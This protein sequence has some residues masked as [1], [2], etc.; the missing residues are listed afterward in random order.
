MHL[1][2]LLTAKTYEMHM[3][4]SASLKLGL[5][6]A[7]MSQSREQS[8]EGE[9]KPKK[10]SDKEAQAKQIDELLKKGAYDVFREEDDA[11]AEKFME[12]DIDQ[13][14]EHSSRVTYGA[15]A[16]SSLGSGL[17]SFS[18]ASFVA[19]TDDGTK[20]VDL[21]DPE[22]WSKAVGLD[23]QEETPEEIAQMLD[24]G[25]KRSRKQVQV[26]DPH[27]DTA[28]AEQ[29]KKDKIALEKLLEKEEKE[30]L[31]HEQ[32]VKKQE[33]K[34][35]KRRDKE[36][37]EKVS[38]EKQYDTSSKPALPIKLLPLGITK[39]VKDKEVFEP[40][41]KKSKKNERMQ[42][43]KKAENA[44][45][46]LERLKQAWEVPQR[47]RAIAAA[48]RF[49]FARFCK[50]RSESNLSGLPL[51]DLES[52]LRAFI[53]QLSLQVAVSLS[54]QSRTSVTSNLR[55]LLKEWL[56][57]NS[58]QELNW[59]CD[60]VRTALQSQ[61]EVENLERE[62]R[63]PLILTDPA[64]IA[65]LRQ[66]AALRSLR[67]IGILSRL[68]CF[69][70]D[71][72][73][74]ILGNLGHES[75]GK[76]GCSS[77][78]LATLDADLKARFVTTEELSL[79][80]GTFY[81][82]LNLKAPATWWDRDCDISLLVGSF[83]HG[84]GNYESMRNDF[85]LPFLERIARVSQYDAASIDAAEIFRTASSAAV[86]VFDDALEAA[87]VKAELEVQAAVAA[88]AKAASKREEDAALLRKG[89]AEAEAVMSEMP[90][91]QVED[92]FAF[93][94]TDSHFVTLP[95]LIKHVHDSVRDHSSLVVKEHENS[96]RGLFPVESKM[97][98]DLA[99]DEV[100]V[101]F[102][103]DNGEEERL[104]SMPDARVLDFRLRCILDAVEKEAHSDSFHPEDWDEP[105]SEPLWN[106][107]PVIM[108]LI[109]VHKHAINEFAPELIEIA[110]EFSGIGIG[111][112]QC[113]SS[114]RTLNDGSD[115]G[116]GPASVKLSQ[117]AYG[118]EAPRYLRALGV[119]MNLTRY[120]ITGLVHARESC[121][122]ELLA[123]ESLRYYG[124][125]DARSASRIT[126]GE[127]DLNGETKRIQ[128][129]C[130]Q[131]DTDIEKAK[132][133]EGVDPNNRIPC[134]FLSNADL[135]AMTCVAVLFFGFPLKSDEV[136]INP[137]LL[138][139]LSK[140][141]GVAVVN[142]ALNS[143][144][145]ESF[146]DQIV[147]ALPSCTVPDITQL[148][149]Y[150][151]KFLLPH[152]LRLCVNGNGSSTRNARGS[153]G[154]Y[155]TAFGVSVHPEPSKPQPSP[156]PDP[157]VILE[158]HSLESVGYANAILRRVQLLRS[159]IYVCSE[160]FEIVGNLTRSES[161]GYLRDMPIWWCP[162]VHDTAL[163][164]QVAS[165]GV[166][167]ILKNRIEHPIFKPKSVEDFFLAKLNDTS[168]T[169]LPVR[170]TDSQKATAWAKKHSNDFPSLFQLERRLAH[171]CSK[172]TVGAHDDYRYD[173]V[174]MFD[175]GAWPR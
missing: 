103:N 148:A 29:R 118:T 102:T 76:R 166:F 65:E 13:L 48:I 89:G 90:D 2:S 6:R 173:S 39:E 123:G 50:L 97:D 32:K 56:G 117:V 104:L 36:K 153:H 64:F 24:D 27:A 144:S 150:V 84:L 53:Y 126:S 44:N 51:Q 146:R 128:S 69:I 38:S 72:L 67:R 82:G 20:D 171:L 34:E 28:E 23:V 151:E 35:R 93:D 96:S 3:F 170:N 159:S 71:C 57:F 132:K 11:E 1:E 131:L 78:D 100:D 80:V 33:A 164:V 135:R 163:L 129:D 109:R 168:N 143:F 47:N 99:P 43:L 95:R 152:C 17:G 25:V 154:D 110:P 136:K 68:N 12:T 37:Q 112:N 134:D 169:S 14:L 122:G 75:L 108:T 19:N 58:A 175:H 137:T 158:H 160:R 60:A 149:L 133:F 30:R 87:R 165:G 8:E 21:D 74:S 40:K 15:S 141:S 138:E 107:S 41:P 116:Y 157:C 161:M 113:G 42:A 31:R 105:S 26:Y 16:T 52:F 46:V 70:N 18:K 142:G 86:I 147:S 114:H 49:G 22:F 92:A 174:P 119:P 55:L 155:A 130:S 172:A 63:L 106:T 5:E 61:L 156:L 88:A 125:E 101:T 91:T 115:Y 85:E 59:I 4:H 121:A 9:D 77:S 73:D 167:S 62:L 124:A 162:W 54:F 66:G 79:V 10:K 7:V 111:S 83:I 127:V 120:A 139:D 140:D 145:Q 81:K 45:P 98:S 94:G